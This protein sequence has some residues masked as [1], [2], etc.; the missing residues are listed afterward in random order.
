VDKFIIIISTLIVIAV[1]QLIK[2]K[3]NI[4]TF[5]Y[6]IIGLF[7]VIFLWGYFVTRNSNTGVAWPWYLAVLLYGIPVFIAFVVINIFEYFKKQN[8]TL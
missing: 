3:T 7:G 2:M 4:R 5:N 6:I 8:E 1:G